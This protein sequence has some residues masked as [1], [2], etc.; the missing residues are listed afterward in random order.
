[1]RVFLILL[2]L[3]ATVAAEPRRIDL[4]FPQLKERIPVIFPDNHDMSRKWPA[5]FYY[6]GTGGSP[7]TEL[8]RAHTGTD[9]W[10][11]VGMTYEKGG[12]LLASAE[13]I[14][15]ERK[16][17]TSV[18]DHLVKNYNL[19]RSR[20]YVAGFSKGGWM[21]GFLL[22]RD[23]TLAGGIILGAGH[24]FVIQKPRRFSKPKPIFVGI[25]RPDAHYPFALRT[26]VHYRP[27]GARTTLETWQG[28]GHS[29]PE[30]GSQ[31]LRQWLALEAN[32]AADQ[33]EA[34]EKWVTFRLDV[35]KGMPD[36][37]DQW[38]ALREL[39]ATPYLRTLGES[40]T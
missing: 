21:S 24:N 15:R 25:G 22:Q 33:K 20:I 23:P 19:D 7:T 3:S 12:N 14:D 5:V 29:F 26:L 40:W 18:R 39:E 2:A 35:I 30:K 16:F 13:S 38:F 6:H 27:L 36:L 1:M 31:A 32:P 37:V 28:L 34:A 11:V 9:D 8:I 10:F 17:F 4:G